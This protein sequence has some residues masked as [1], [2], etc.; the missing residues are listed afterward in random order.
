[1]TYTEIYAVRPNGDITEYGEAHNAWGGAMHIWVTLRDKYGTHGVHGFDFSLTW[2]S[3][4]K[5]SERD[6]WVMAGTFDKVII[7]KEQLPTYRNFLR[8]FA[9]EYPTQNLEEQISLLDRAIL[10]DTVRGICF[11]QTSV[12]S[13]P[14]WIYDES[15]DEEGKPYNVDVGTKHW[16]LMPEALKET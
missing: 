3:A 6:Q 13:N 16:F 1:M 10:D 7:P 8:S 2:G 4:N 15:N 12:N 9:N 11:N 5:M 14:W